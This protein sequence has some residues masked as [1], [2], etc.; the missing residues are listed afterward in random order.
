M[1]SA[2]VF[3]YSYIVS[4]VCLRDHRRSVQS[5]DPF[6]RYVQETLV[7]YNNSDVLNF[8][9]QNIYFVSWCI[10]II[11]II[12]F[13]IFMQNIYYCIFATNH[14][15]TIYSVAGVLHLQ[16]VLLVMLFHMLN[17]LYF[18]INTSRSMCVVPNM[19]LFYTCLISCC[20][21]MFLRCFL[22]VILKWFQLPLL[23]LVSSLGLHWKYTVFV[24]YCFRT[25]SA[26]WSYLSHYY[27]YYYYY[28]CYCI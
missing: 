22:W 21:C 6:W 27:Y 23:W 2:H 19:A 20:L 18:Y 12:V 5:T 24:L 4:G 11:I 10:I 28:Y 13:I 26:S 14:V 25:F 15:S 16:I 9:R 17:V 1:L 8:R 3:I 7:C